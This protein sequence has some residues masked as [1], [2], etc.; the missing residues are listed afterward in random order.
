MRSSNFRL[1]QRTYSWTELQLARIW[2]DVCQ[3][4]RDRADHPGPHRPCVASS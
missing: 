4:A 1:Y 3:L 2:E